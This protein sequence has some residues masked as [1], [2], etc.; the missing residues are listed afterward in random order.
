MGVINVENNKTS[1]V[2]PTE[3]LINELLVKIKPIPS[4]KYEPNIGIWLFNA[5]FAVFIEIPSMLDAVN[6]LTV[7]KDMNIV[8]TIPT[9]QLN[10]LEKNFEN[11]SSFTLL[12]I[13]PTIL[14]T[15]LKIKIGIN[16]I[17]NIFVINVVNTAKI[18]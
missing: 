8:N 1:P 7:K 14:K 15:T 4:D 17:V 18:G 13:F 11:L 12:E 2:T 10:R 3:F 16:T 9:I 5:N 6:P